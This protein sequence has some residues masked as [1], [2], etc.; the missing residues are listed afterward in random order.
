MKTEY[1]NQ[2][3]LQTASAI[4]RNGERTISRIADLFMALFALDGWEMLISA[5]HIDAW[6]GFIQSLP[7]VCTLA[8]L[9]LLF[10]WIVKPVLSDKPIFSVSCMGVLSGIKHFVELVIGIYV[11]WGFF[12]YAAGKQQLI[13]P[14]VIA[15][16]SILGLICVRGVLYVL[17]KANAIRCFAKEAR[18]AISELCKQ[19]QENRVKSR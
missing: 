7:Y 14:V 11:V 17:S 5:Q 15:V 13:Y 4:L 10:L 3:R 18:T 2:N 1:L 8:L 16:I 6:T 9:F 12:T 19:R